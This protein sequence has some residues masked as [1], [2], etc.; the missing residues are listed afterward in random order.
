MN[1]AKRWRTIAWC[2]GVTAAVLFLAATFL[3]ISAGQSQ[4]DHFYTRSG[5]LRRKLGIACLLWGIPI[6]FGAV[7]CTVGY[8][9][10]REDDR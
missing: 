4:V 7:I 8:Y 1:S 2:A 5:M 3:F 6:A 9:D 10:H